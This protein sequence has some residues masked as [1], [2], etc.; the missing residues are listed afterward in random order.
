MKKY[1]KFTGFLELME[2]LDKY[3]DF[4]SVSE[5]SI[6]SAGSPTKNIKLI[7]PSQISVYFIGITNHDNGDL[8]VRTELGNIK[9]WLKPENKNS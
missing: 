2:N 7:N 3:E 1:Y 4:V 9:F 5:K 8:T 6:P